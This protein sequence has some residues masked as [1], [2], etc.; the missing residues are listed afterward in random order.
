MIAYEPEQISTYDILKVFW[1]NHDPTTQYRQGND[2]GTQYPAV[3]LLDERGAAAV[4]VEAT[5]DAYAHVF[6][7]RGFDPISTEIEPAEGREFYYAED[8]HQQYLYKVPHGYDCHANTGLRFHRWCDLDPYSQHELLGPRETVQ[9]G[10]GTSSSGNP[11]LGTQEGGGQGGWEA[12]LVQRML[13]V[14]RKRGSGSSRGNQQL[15]VRRGTASLE[16]LALARMNGVFSGRL[17]QDDFVKSNAT[18]TCTRLLPDQQGWRS[19][20]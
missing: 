13:T 9:L 14:E 18:K 17:E 10:T 2:I 8:Y 20:V 4:V 16:Q 1:E 12:E 3:P 7:E 6:A 15:R 11:S 5:R 19:K